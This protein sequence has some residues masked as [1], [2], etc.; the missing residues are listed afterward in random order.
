MISY[1]APTRIDLAGG[2]VDIWPLYLML[3]NSATL[4]VAIDLYARVDLKNLNKNKVVVHSRDL[5]S[6]LEYEDID[7]VRQKSDLELITSLI[8][9][10]RGLTGGFK[11]TSNCCAPQGSGLGGSSALSVAVNAV[12]DEY[13]SENQS[14]SVT[15]II[16]FIQ[17]VETSIL[18]YPTGV[19]DYYPALLG[20]VLLLKYRKGSNHSCEKINLETDFIE[21]HIIL[22]YTGKSRLSSDTNWRVYRAFL[23]NDPEVRD[24]LKIINKATHKAGEALESCNIKKLGEAI[25]EE[26][27]NRK[28]LA[29]G[30]ESK[31]LKKFMDLAMYKGALAVNVCGAGG[32]GCFFALTDEKNY[33]RIVKALKKAGA[34][35]MDFN[36][37][38]KPEIS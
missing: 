15:D 28:L 25:R 27:E 7:S 8:K 6:Y 9:A 20:G 16:S 10:K 31:S 24:A 19:Q 30:I 13:T 34:Q 14:S 2:T 18:G 5:D 17:D 1:R 35:I 3:E 12:L 23:E 26:W 36:V 32:G 4:N 22:S 21:K 33:P 37:S 11:L 29:D 38:S